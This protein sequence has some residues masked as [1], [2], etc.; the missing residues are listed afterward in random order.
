M[1][2]DNQYRSSLESRVGSWVGPLG[3]LY[4]AFQVPYAIPRTYTPDFS[5]EHEGVHVEVKGYFRAG[6]RQKYAAIAEQMV[7]DGWTY[8]FILQNPNK[9]VGKG[10]KLTMGGWCDK[11][12]IT[13]FA[14]YDASGFELWLEEVSNDENS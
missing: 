13:W 4:E 8:V 2:S 9:P 5:F 3:G 1:G 6:D 12:G 7:D 14:E 11:H 10:A